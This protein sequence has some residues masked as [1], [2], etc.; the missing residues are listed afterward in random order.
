MI[1][2]QGHLPEVCWSLG[3]GGHFVWNAGILGSGSGTGIF[4]FTSAGLVKSRPRALIPLQSDAI[5]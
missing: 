4:Y 1:S 2:K 3:G 5:P